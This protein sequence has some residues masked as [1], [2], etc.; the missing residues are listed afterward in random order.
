[1]IIASNPLVVAIS[2]F[3]QNFNILLSI[4]ENTYVSLSRYLV[5]S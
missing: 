5:F 4:I 3:S 1:M 2:F